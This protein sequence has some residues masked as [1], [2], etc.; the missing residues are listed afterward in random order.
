MCHSK[1]ILLGRKQYNG[2]SDVMTFYITEEVFTLMLHRTR[3]RI[4]VLLCLLYFNNKALEN[5]LEKINIQ[6]LKIINMTITIS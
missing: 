2:A 1:V 4:C 6:D 5:K 3:V